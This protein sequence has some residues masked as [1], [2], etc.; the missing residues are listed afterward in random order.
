VCARDSSAAHAR[1]SRFVDDPSDQEG[2]RAGPYK[3][4]RGPNGDAWVNAGG[5]DYSPVA[6]FR[7]HPPEDEGNRRGLSRRDVTQAVITVPL[8]FNDAQR[9]ATKDAGQIAGP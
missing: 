4:T 5:K 7:L 3:I 1:A 6:D 2:H 9:Q 8:T